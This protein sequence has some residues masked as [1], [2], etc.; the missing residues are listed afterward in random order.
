MSQI[1]EAQVQLT[2]E[3]KK[4]SELTILLKLGLGTIS[5]RAETTLG[6][7]GVEMAFMWL[8]KAKGALG[9]TNPYP[10]SANPQSPV[11]EPAQDT[12]SELSEEVKS[13]ISGPKKAKEL[14][15]V[16]IKQARKMLEELCKA[17]QNDLQIM[18]ENRIYQLCIQNAWGHAQEG[19]MRLGQVL[20]LIRD[21]DGKAPV[22]EKAPAKEKEKKK[23]K[24]VKEPKA[25]KPLKE[26]APKATGKGKSAKKGGEAPA[27]GPSVEPTKSAAN[28]GNTDN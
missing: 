10:E 14:E 22:K 7:R 24:K 9:A 28:A 23:E 6:L 25:P 3:R 12:V 5:R 17:I 26:K 1:L 2:D 11:I 16:F 21:E 8:G 13:V 18:T 4:L 20:G 27:S 19:K 15:V